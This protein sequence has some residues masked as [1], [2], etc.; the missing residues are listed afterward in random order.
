M[1]NKVTDNFE[2]FE[3][4][5]A[6]WYWTSH[7]HGGMWCEKYSAMCQIMGEYGLS[8][9]PDIDFDN[10]NDDEYYMAIQYYHELNEDNWKETFEAWCE[11]MDTK[12]EDEAC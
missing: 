4:A 6:L 9:I 3:M 12:W 2:A 1:I 11:Y 10:E 8:N 5:F 7:W